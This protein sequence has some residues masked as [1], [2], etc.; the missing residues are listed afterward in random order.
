MDRGLGMKRAIFIIPPL[1]AFLAI[2]LVGHGAS[3]K[4]AYFTCGPRG[5][6]CTYK[7]EEPW[8]GS[9]KFYEIMHDELVELRVEEI[10]PEFIRYYKKKGGYKNPVTLNR[11]TLINKWGDKCK[12]IDGP[13]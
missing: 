11:V 3:A 13:K 6:E 9:D 2:I 12:I 10:T 8:F 5:Y 1:V 4:T 7:L